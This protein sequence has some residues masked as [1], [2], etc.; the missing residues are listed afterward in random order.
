MLS[1]YHFT[2]A[3]RFIRYVQ[4]D[5][6]SDPNSNTSP[7]TEKQRNLSRLLKE[8]LE[9]L[10][11]ED[12][13]LDAFGYVYATI[14]ANTDKKVPVICFCSH[15]DTAPDSSGTN[16]KPILHKHYNGEDIVLPDDT[17]QVIS[18]KDYPY[19][20]EHIGHDIITASGLTLLGADDKAGVSIIM[21]LAN[22]L[23]SHPEV[24]HGTIKIL[25]TPDEEVG[26]GTAKV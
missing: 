18:V 10:G 12:V 3:E 7:S 17:S 8:E 16:V 6:Q 24:K 25:F 26:K 9:H 14:P 21:D 5:T 4:I 1:T 22:Y 20:K 23:A 13:Q 2:A 19:L 11:A 15:V